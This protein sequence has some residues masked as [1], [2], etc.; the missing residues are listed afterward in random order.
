[1]A[2]APGGGTQYA[3]PRRGARLLSPGPGRTR[4]E[5]FLDVGEP[6][7]PLDLGIPEPR[8]R[9][10]GLMGRVHHDRTKAGAW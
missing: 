4:L 10:P 7:A 5:D 9:P 3:L 8:L 2:R 6:E 1:M